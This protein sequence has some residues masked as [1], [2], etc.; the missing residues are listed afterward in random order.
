MYETYDNTS[1][2][3]VAKE[4]TAANGGARG[5]KAH[6]PASGVCGVT[7]SKAQAILDV[8]PLLAKFG[9]DLYFV[10]HDHNYETTWP[11]YQGHAQQLNY[12]NPCAPV[13][14][15]SG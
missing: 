8:E 10:G 1:E 9:V 11:V 12:V 4:R 3:N 5:W 15:L 6:R 13:H 14:I 2:A 7:P